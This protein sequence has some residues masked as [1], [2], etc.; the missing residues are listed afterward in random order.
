VFSFLN[1]RVLVLLIAFALI[2][3]FIWYAG[4]Y[5]AFGVYRPLESE[6]ARLVVIGLVVACWILS[7]VI[8]FLRATRATDR[9]MGAVV[10]QVRREKERPS[11]EAAKLR[12]R[13]EEA[14]AALKQRG[15]RSLYDLP[16][17]VFIGAPGSGKTTA[18]VNS[19]LRFPLEQRVGKG[20]V[21][22]I[23][24][25][26]NCDW[27]FTDEAVFLDTAGRYTTQDSDEASDS[28]GWKEFLALLRGYRERRPLNGVLLTI[29]CQDLLTQSDAE[30][31]AH[32]DAARRRLNEL[33]DEL[34]VQL[35]VYV[36]VTKCDMVPGFTDYFDDLT[37]EQRAQVWGVTFPFEQ[38]ASGEA[39]D[40]VATEFDALM[41]RLNRRVF[42]RLEEERGGR[43]RAAV[44]AFPQQMGALRDLVAQFVA[45]VFSTSRGDRQ[46]V[47]L[48]G[49]Y[50]TSGTQDGTQI[51]RLLGAIS[52]RF[53]VAADA[54]APPA[55]RGKAYFVERLLKQVVIGES[56]IAGVNRRLEMRKAAW[57]IGAYA[58]TML[59]AVVGLIALSVSYAANR[60]YV[61]QVTSDVATLKRVRPPIGRASIEAFLPVLNA[62]RAVSDS[63]NRYRDGAPWSMR[64]GLY[65][66]NSIG[67][68]ARDAYL[69]DLDGIVL[70][71]FAARVRQHLIEYAAEPEKLY[72]Y[73]KAYLMLG[74]ARHYDKKYLQFVADVE[75]PPPIG[76]SSAASPSPHVH[77]LLEYSDTLRPLPVDAAL[78]AQARGSVR[79]ASI[80]RI[81]YGQLQRRYRS[82]GTDGVRLDVLAGL[83]AEKVLRRRSGRPFS[84][85]IPAIYTQKVFKEITG[86]G[87]R[88]FVNQFAADEWVWGSGSSVLSASLTKLG[89][90][91]ADIYERDYANAW[92]ALLSDLQIVPFATV[93]QYAEALSILGGPT[94]PL[95]GVLKIASENTSLVAGSRDQTTPQSLR[96]RLV[97]TTNDIFNKAQQKISGG[98]LPGA[99]VTQRFQPIQR[100]VS[101]APAPIDGILD[102]VRKIRDQLARLGPQVG[103][104]EPLRALTDPALLQLWQALLQDAATLPPPV[105][106]LAADIVNNA[107]GSVVND[108]RRELDKRYD[109]EVVA[110]CRQLIDGR[111]PFG[112]GG[113]VSLADFSELFADG[114]VYDKFFA[115][116]LAPLVDTLQPQWTWRGSPTSSSPE[117]L[118]QFQRAARIRRMFFPPGAKTPEL[119][120]T[121]RLSNVDARALRFYLEINGHRFEARPGAASESP[122]SWPATDKAGVV[123]AAFEDREATAEYIRTGTGPFALFRMIDDKQRSTPGESDAQTLL[124]FETKYHQALATIVPSEGVRN[125]FSASDWRQFRCDR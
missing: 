74:D 85:P 81:M 122:A 111:Y 106:T 50:F 58:A 120:F 67:N 51:D 105:D 23:G 43:R 99:L 123:Y 73:L 113:D 47:L 80:A 92:D 36:L 14:I 96:D 33:T 49:V 118:N 65:Q 42:A 55:G 93:Q 109:A 69:R 20:A 28:E 24:G 41:S 90:D 22:G 25:T 86:A 88:P 16:W 1:R 60:T 64:W 31:D 35:P 59:V 39:S 68:A 121:V 3:I 102:Q 104:G 7:R 125:P 19:G 116:Q 38:T 110:R 115:D 46:Q 79:Q 91:L 15:G 18:L 30:R 11:A 56:G 114:G 100:L 53:G 48:R 57:Q 44:F 75:W 5:F 95:R 9:L 21:R 37:Q 34:Q 61:E 82:D 62:V 117:I 119:N 8:R 10:N 63:A 71:R 45:D 72:L 108:A 124:R 83:G 89:P 66:G 98:A 29:S 112:N 32:V 12:E 107:R 2:A 87:M 26:R 77:N 76:P 52:R 13:F 97:D 40:G 54:V 94:S 4:P 84:E 70:P 27:W 6:D 103:G 17:Y 101:G 78:V